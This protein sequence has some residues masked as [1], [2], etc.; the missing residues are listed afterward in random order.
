V[1]TLSPHLVDGSADCRL[2]AAGTDRGLP[3]WCLTSARRDHVAHDHFIDIVDAHSCAV[4]P[5]GTR[6]RSRS[7]F[8]W[9]ITPNTATV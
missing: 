4:A 6:T 5:H 8:G 3:G 7:D 2:E 9:T 1:G